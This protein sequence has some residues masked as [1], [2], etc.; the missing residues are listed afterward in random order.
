M[1]YLGYILN[2]CDSIKRYIM[3]PTINKTDIV[4]TINDLPE[5]TTV[6]EAIERLTVLHKVSVGLRQSEEGKGMSQ[7]QV[8]D[9]FRERR[10]RRS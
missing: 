1:G 8:E 9:H 6:E 3:N 7:Q 4:Q 10:N 2:S 5:E